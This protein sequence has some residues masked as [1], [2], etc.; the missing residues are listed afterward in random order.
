MIDMRRVLSRLGTGSYAVTRTADFTDTLGRLDAASTSSFNIDAVVSQV[1][2]KD[3]AVMPEGA[4]VNDA[5]MVWTDTT[6]L[7]TPYPDKI[8]IGGL[9]YEVSKVW[10]RSTHGQY[11][12]A[13][14]IR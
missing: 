14:V 13:M 6:L 10:P 9:V 3:W 5:L 11:C 4:A 7:V 1:P 2:S 12:K 8:T